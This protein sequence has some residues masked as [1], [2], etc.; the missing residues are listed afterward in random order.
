MIA[1]MLIKATSVNAAPAIYVILAAVVS[2]LVVIRL[3]EPAH[4]PFNR[5]N[6]GAQNG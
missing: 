1:V 6:I 4:I 3:P 2:L 5:R